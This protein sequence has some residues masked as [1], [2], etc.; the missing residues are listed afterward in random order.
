MHRSS[1]KT[2]PPEVAPKVVA[3]PNRLYDTTCLQRA[4]V[5]QPVLARIPDI[6]GT[7]ASCRNWTK[8]LPASVASAE[9]FDTFNQCDLLV[10]YRYI[11]FHRIDRC[12]RWHVGRIVSDK[13]RP[14]LIDALD[15][16]WVSMHGPMGEL[17]MDG[18]SVIATDEA[19][20]SYRRRNGITYVPRALAQQVCHIDR[21][22]ALLR[23]TLH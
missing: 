19:A 5:P 18:E 9:L 14:T 20:R 7:C 10:I 4:G 17:I 22:G 3:C 21:R 2:E 12:T 6:V 23:D 16:L 11:V 8:Q 1:S 15:S 13:E